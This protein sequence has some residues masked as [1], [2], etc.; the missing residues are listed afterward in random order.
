[1]SFNPL[2]IINP[3][4]AESAQT[5]QYTAVNTRTRVDKFTATNISASNQTISVNIVSAGNVV[6]TSN[7]IVKTRQL[8][9]NETYTFPEIV[10]K[11]LL[12]GW[13]ISTIA[14][15]SSAIVISADGTEYTS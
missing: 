13:S 14:G 4:F 2:P 15:A 12:N 3:K 1:M 8:A 10:G 11:Y 7:L 5:T 6:G 9:P